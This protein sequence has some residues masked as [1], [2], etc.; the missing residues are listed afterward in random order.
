[1]NSVRQCRLSRKRSLW[2]CYLL[3]LWRFSVC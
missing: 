1:M 3:Y 2:L